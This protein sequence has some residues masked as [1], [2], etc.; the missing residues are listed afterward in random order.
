VQGEW[1]TGFY[2]CCGTVDTPSGEAVGGCGLCCM[3]CCCSCMV[4]SENSEYISS[5]EG[6]LFVRKG[7]CAMAAVAYFIA[8]QRVPE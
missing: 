6:G 3:A 8:G 7:N 2:D 5:T 4:F 1:S